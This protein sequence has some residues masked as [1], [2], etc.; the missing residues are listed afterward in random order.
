MKLTS[1]F[2]LHVY[3]VYSVCFR[4]DVAKQKILPSILHQIGN[5]PL[6]QINKIHKSL[7]LQ[8]QMCTFCSVLWNLKALMNPDNTT[9]TGHPDLFY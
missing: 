6:V 8:C 9:K 2:L 7:G 3:I 5:T 4:V 1:V